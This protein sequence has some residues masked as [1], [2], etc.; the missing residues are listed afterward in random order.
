MQKFEAGY[1]LH[2]RL[3]ECVQ[4][5]ALMLRIADFR[6]LLLL[7]RGLLA[8]R[9]AVHAFLHSSDELHERYQLTNTRMKL[10]DQTF[11]LH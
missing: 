4:D 2:Q 1:H 8:A 10:D 7:D 11:G 9:V 6:L 5:R 3:I